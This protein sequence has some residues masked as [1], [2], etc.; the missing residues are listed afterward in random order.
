MRKKTGLDFEELM[1]QGWPRTIRGLPD[2]WDEETNV[3]W[4]AKIPG[5][6]WGSPIVL[7]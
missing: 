7:G 2:T 5:W 1:A 6:G 4:K 3:L